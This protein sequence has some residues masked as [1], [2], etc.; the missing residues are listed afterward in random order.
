MGVRISARPGCVLAALLAA[1]SVLT[2][3]L[4]CRSLAVGKVAATAL[5]TVLPE[6]EL[7]GKPHLIGFYADQSMEAK[8][9][10]Y[11]GDLLEK[12]IPGVHIVWL[13]AWDNPLNERLRATIDLRRCQRRCAQ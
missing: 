5:R 3:S 1:C 11:L 2:C 12:E 8:R 9:M 13:E 6:P 4:S 10:K 7:A